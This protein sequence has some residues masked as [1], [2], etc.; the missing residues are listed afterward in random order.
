MS[1][2][3]LAGLVLLF[4]IS[5]PARPQQPSSS[6]PPPPAPQSATPAQSQKPGTQPRDDTD[7]VRIT[8]SLVQIDAV[9][10]KDGKQV[11]DLTAEDFEI[12][13]DGRKQVITN[14]SYVSNV[15][16]SPADTAVKRDMKK[17][18][19][20]PVVPP[21]IRPENSRRTIA[22]VVDD[23]GISMESM[24]PVKK[25]LRK[26]IEEQMQPNDLVA[27]IRTGGDVGALQQF[28]AD[29]RL[30][31]RAVDS[32]RRNPCSRMGNTVFSPLG[33]GNNGVALCA[34][35]AMRLTARSLRFVVQGMGE[36]PG[37]KS[38]IILSD[39]LPLDIPDL[40]SLERG[41]MG[42]GGN[43]NARGTNA[44][45]IA[46][47]SDRASPFS[48][49]AAVKK[50]ADL[51]IR[52]S[53]VIYGV[54]TRGLQSPGI[55]AADGFAQIGARGTTH[56]TNQTT[57]IM[58]QRSRQIQDGRAGTEL[59]ARETGG[60][61][62]RNSN[63]FQLQRVMSDQEGYYLIGYRPTQETFNRRF[64]HI[65]ARV[66][67]GGVSVRTREGFF[68][69]TDEDARPPERTNR[70]KLNLAL[71]S[72]FGA[73]DID[74]QLTTLFA[75]TAATGA[76]LRSLVYFQARDL[77]FAEETDGWHK[78]TF[79]LSGIIF[80]DNGAVAHQT[81][82][83]RSLRLRGNDYRRVLRR[84]LVYQL[85]IP[86]RRP[87][88]YQFR[89]AVRDASSSRLGT[90]GQ[91][92][93]VPN[94][95]NGWLALSG[96]TVSGFLD[97]KESE[98]AAANPETTQPTAGDREAMTGPAQRRFRTPSNLYFGYVIYNVQLDKATRQTGLI[99]AIRILRDGKIIFDG[100]PKAVDLTGQSDSQRITAGGGLQLGT[101]MAPGEYI[102]QITVT[103][104]L[105]KEKQRTTTQW[106]DF[107]IVK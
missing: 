3:S 93:E 92:V 55:T 53:V 99:A 72:P 58:S 44:E 25:Q 57:S 100:Q 18:D 13:E 50:I 37:R 102:L 35:E 80:G 106:I 69:V 88:S 67:R 4:S 85:D 19:D 74:V 62:I 10:T 89:V 73:V 97:S 28:T 27:I 30:L 21:A 2:R 43:E 52:S 38:M 36:L 17:R 29:K 70:D 103:D 81:T 105:A 65:K 7:V 101:E 24:A 59:M 15:S 11:T 14:F 23:L 31:Y 49:E 91:F 107:E 54:D 60:F 84:G 39:S 33:A 40:E 12:F 64:H 51:A 47:S 32:L 90:A 1:K 76:Q 95:N 94:L 56:I 77:T 83:T 75:N 16:A 68:G 87:G 20:L 5:L 45:T 6:P 79:D 104:L 86:V 34:S 26:F 9:V 78:A 41:P 98:P 82:E 8:T 71:M 96:L 61:L 42:P 66:K 63:D 46:A 48:N 22:L